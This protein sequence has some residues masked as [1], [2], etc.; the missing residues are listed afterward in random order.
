MVSAEVRKE[1]EVRP[2]SRVRGEGRVRAKVRVRGLKKRI[3]APFFFG[4]FQCFSLQ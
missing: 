3:C 1:G 4:R 2:K